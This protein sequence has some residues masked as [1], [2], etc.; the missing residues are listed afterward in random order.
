MKIKE[1]IGLDS[2]GRNRL[3]NFYSC[4]CCGV[5]YKKQARLSV[6]S[7]YEHYCSVSCG[8]KDNINNTHIEF[9]CANCGIVFF[10]TKSK[11]KNS[12]HNI[13]FCSRACKDK[14][15]SYITEIQPAH[16]NTG[17]GKSSYRSKALNN[18]PNVCAVCEYD[19]VDA[20]EVHHIDKDRQNN[21]LSNLLVLCA[22]C[23][24]LIHKNKIKI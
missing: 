3:F 6:G 21:S 17:T 13:Y 12:K 16:Y 18:L 15:Q 20:L 24:T 5:E 23:H 2:E 14:G 8:N 11:L 22:N 4:D 7:K 1:E 19:N 10:R 9:C